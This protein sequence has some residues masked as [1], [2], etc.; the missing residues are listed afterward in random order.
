MVKKLDMRDTSKQ[1]KAGENTPK[2]KGKKSISIEKELIEEL[3]LLAWYQRKTH[4]EIVEDALR[5]YLSQNQKVI[6]KAKEVNPWE[7]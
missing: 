3:E 6:K 4:S 5:M 7:A 1:D 2:E